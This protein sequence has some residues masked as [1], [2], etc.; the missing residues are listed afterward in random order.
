M[1]KFICFIIGAIFL[2]ACEKKNSNYN[3]LYN[4][5]QNKDKEMTVDFTYEYIHYPKEISFSARGK[6]VDY[7]SWDFGDGSGGGTPNPINIF[8]ETGTYDV[9]LTGCKFNSSETKTCTKTIKVEVNE[10]YYKGCRFITDLPAENKYYSVSL[11][12]KTREWSYS[13]ISVEKITGSMLPYDITFNPILMDWLDKDEYYYV[14]IRYHDTVNDKGTVC[15]SE[16]LY[17]SDIKK[18]HVFGDYMVWRNDYK[19]GVE[20]LV[21]YK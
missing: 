14:V 11:Y 4:Y 6:Y 12:N 15:F 8:W 20:I 13:F 7:F 2:C 1:K 3:T 19:M 18:Y 17:T 5:N 9:T 16:K 21:E 10:V